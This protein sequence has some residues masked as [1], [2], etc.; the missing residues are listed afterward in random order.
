MKKGE[1]EFES[2]SDRGWNGLI[3]S[4]CMD[5]VTE[6]DKVRNGGDQKQASHRIELEEQRKSL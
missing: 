1:Q 4:G 3:S 6:V 2:T 5:K